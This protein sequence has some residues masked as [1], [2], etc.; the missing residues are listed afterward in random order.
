MWFGNW[1]ITAI[2]NATYS[3]IILKTSDDMFVT[4]I[5]S[6]NI[7]NQTLVGTDTSVIYSPLFQYAREAG[8]IDFV[9][10][11]PFVSGGVK[12]FDTEEI[13]SCSTVSQFAS[14]TLPNRGNFYAIGTNALV[15][16]D[17]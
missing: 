7:I 13:L 12:L 8:K 2:S 11:A 3:A 14:I 10:H 9:D 6:A 15:P 4:T 5:N 1:T 17:E 16:I